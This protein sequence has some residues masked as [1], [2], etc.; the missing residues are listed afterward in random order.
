MPGQTLYAL[1]LATLAGAAAPAYAN[2]GGFSNTG[3]TASVASSVSITT[4]VAAP[5]GSLTMHCPITGA[6]T[7]SGGSFKYFSS[8]GTEFINAIFVS[9]EFAE[10]CSGGGRTRTCGYTFTGFIRGTFTLDGSA[11][12]IEGTTHQ[13]F[14]VGQA[15][16]GRSSYNS[17]YTPFYYSDGEQILRSDDLQGRNQVA[18]GSIG[19]GVGQFYG[20][21]GIALDASGRIYVADTYNCRIVRFNDMKGTD[22]VS[23]GGKCGPGK[24]EFRNP[25]GVAVNSAGEIYVLDGGNSRIVRL[26]DMKGS[27]WEAY[28]RAGTGKG[29]FAPYDESIALDASGRIYVADTRNQ[30]VVRIDNIAGDNWIALTKSPP[31]AGAAQR[32]LVSPISVAVGSAGRIYIADNGGAEPAVVRVD[33]MTGANWTTMDVGAAPINGISIDPSGTLFVSGGGVRLVDEMSGVLSS[34][35]PVAPLGPYYVFG[36]TP[37]RTASPPPPAMSLSSRTLSFGNQRVGT[38]SAS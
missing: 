14:E 34:S 25:S 4:D 3:G 24:G 36:A 2:Q 5:K 19:D 29:Q 23:Y 12:A 35:P 6:A 18:F 11:Q 38:K 26:D 32:S 13:S 21:L 17:A 15:A 22:W 33:N 16:T 27:H 31:A 8:D 28:G 1:I 9:G 7:C 30:R 10:S 20:S 37:L